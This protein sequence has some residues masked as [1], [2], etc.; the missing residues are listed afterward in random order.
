MFGKVILCSLFSLIF[1][2]SVFAELPVYPGAKA[3]PGAAK[4]SMGNINISGMTGPIGNVASNSKSSTYSVPATTKF[5]DV[6]K[7]YA[8][9]LTKQGYTEKAGVNVTGSVGVQSASFGTAN[10]MNTVSIT[11]TQNPVNANEM[12]LSVS[13][14]FTKLN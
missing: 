6:K 11:L 2:T 7:F 8:A 5:E 4:P 13:E 3:V 14:S 9:E 12:L 1:V 10:G